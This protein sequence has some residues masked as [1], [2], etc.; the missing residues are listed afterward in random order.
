MVA[1]NA[2]RPAAYVLDPGAEPFIG[3]YRALAFPREWRQPILDLYQH[4]RRNPET[5]RQIPIRRL[6]AAIRAVAPDL[7]SVA[8]YATLDDSKPWLYT[9]R[10]YPASVVGTLILSWLRTLQPAV[11]SFPQLREAYG[12][13]DIKSL[14]WDLVSVDLAEQIL[15]NGGTSDPAQHLYRLLP[16]VLA[17]G[18]EQLPPYEYC[19]TEVTFRRAATE[20]GAELISWPPSEYRPK[21]QQGRDARPWHFSA[22]IKITVQTV[23]F[24][25]AP[26]IHL[27]TGI[28]RWVRG[29]LSTPTGRD[30]TTYLLSDG[31]WLAGT[32]QTPRFAAAKIGW[33]GREGK[34]AWAGDGPSGILAQL[35]SRDFPSPESL[36]SEAETWIGGQAGVTAAVTHHT[37][38][39]YHGAKPGLMPSERQRLTQWA[40]QAL[41]PQFR[42]VADLM[43]SERK[44]K[45]ARVLKELPSIPKPSAD[46][47]KNPDPATVAKIIERRAEISGDHA[48]LRR[49]LLARAVGADRVLTCHVLYQTD[50][51][52][53][54]LFNAAERN[55]GLRQYSASTGSP[56]T[57]VWRAPEVEVR[58]H[59]VPLG[60]LGAPLGGDGEPTRGKGH[61][62]AVEERRAGVREFLKA[63]QDQSRVVFVE[64]E[65]RNAFRPRTDP[66]GAIRIG[67]ADAGRVSQFITPER[68]AEAQAESEAA[69]SGEKE[70]KLD[71]RAAATWADGLRQIGMRFVPRHSLGDAAI[72]EG[73][74]QLA[75]WIVR[76][77]TG[78]ASRNAQFSPI[79]V[80]I[81]PDQDS[82]MGR[83]PGTAGW[84]P[85]PDLLKGLAGQVRGPELKAAGQ[86]KAET[87]RFIRQVL[88]DLRNEPTVVLAYAQ[89]IRRSWEWLNN[90]H[91]I[92]D[93]IQF[94]NGPVQALDLYGKQL[95][96]IRV[97]D[98]EHNETPQWWAPDGDEF[99]GIATGLW[100]EPDAGED[101]RVFYATTGKASTAQDALRDDTK[102][103]PH[104]NVKSGRLVTNAARNASNPAL[105]EIAVAGCT[106][107]DDPEAWAMYVQQQRFADDYRDDLKFPLILHLAELAHEYALPFGEEAPARIENTTESDDSPAAGD[108]DDSE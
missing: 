5:R 47:A 73:L 49:E 88:S 20:Q 78:E 38:M 103:T 18:I 28:R 22:V 48:R 56:G 33:S 102:L 71:H 36:G 13:L 69:D 107:G 3:L 83:A 24:S 106:T 32:E 25:P 66:K 40:A 43:K 1:Y 42:P 59:A 61:D 105:L 68:H 60:A 86:Q 21:P 94:G 77:N 96:L 67:C 82:V 50:A 12:K 98:A 55:L 92:A 76:R 9:D 2:I 63:L 62:Q 93:K 74:N 11:E 101:N 79:A 85:Y 35:R 58:I 91:V 10:E 23:P 84:V 90:N 27:S 51:V 53:D 14:H 29:R 19:G 30:V 7:V 75:F 89:N 81:R 17:A 95:R 65:G 39:G 4:G 72:P 45:P 99:A 97:R 6:N 31:P 70:G 41:P 15:T 80:L 37:M 8:E 64:L 16:D 34:L 57:R 100:R 54:E 104:L 52:R 46:P 108:G 44:P 87:A 26:R